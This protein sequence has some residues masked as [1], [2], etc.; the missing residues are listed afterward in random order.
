MIG[1]AY[2]NSRQLLGGSSPSYFW[3]NINIMFNPLSC[4]EAEELSFI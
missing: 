1:S 4:T 2:L 3:I